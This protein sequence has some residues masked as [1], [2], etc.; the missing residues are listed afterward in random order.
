MYK[1]VKHVLFIS[2]HQPILIGFREIKLKTSACPRIENIE[3]WMKSNCC[4]KIPETI[5]ENVPALH[6]CPTVFVLT[7]TD[8]KTEPALLFEDKHTIKTKVETFSSLSRAKERIHRRCNICPTKA[9]PF[10]FVCM[11]ATTEKGDLTK[12]VDIQIGSYCISL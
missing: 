11:L 3:R 2:R 9:E 6:L 7:S 1:Y 4:D 5:K 12:Q 8:V 10:L